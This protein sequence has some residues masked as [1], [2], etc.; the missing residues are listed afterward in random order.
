MYSRASKIILYLLGVLLAHLHQRPDL[1]HAMALESVWLP[2][3][4]PLR[5]LELGTWNPANQTAQIRPS[6]VFQHTKRMLMYYS[7]D[8]VGPVW[9]FKPSAVNR[10]L[11]ISNSQRM[12]PRGWWYLGG[13][14]K[15]RNKFLYV[16]GESGME[17]TSSPAKAVSWGAFAVNSEATAFKAAEDPVKEV[18]FK[19]SPP[20]FLATKA[21]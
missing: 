6:R 11:E 16:G 12:C 2:E 18:I 5:N 19:A 15:Q 8:D 7:H 20:N 17:N 21:W 3:W 13:I 10:A 9:D 14:R 1:H 4:T